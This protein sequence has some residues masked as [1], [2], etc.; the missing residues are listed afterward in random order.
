MASRPTEEL[1]AEAACVALTSDTRRFEIHALRPD[2][3][4]QE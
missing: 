4:T 2:V 1:R 3:G